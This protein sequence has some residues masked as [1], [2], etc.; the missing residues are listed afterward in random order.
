MS[1][2]DYIYL[3][4]AATTPTDPDIAQEMVGVMV[5]N[6]GNPSS[7]HALGKAAGGLVEA[8]RNSV[9]ELFHANPQQVIFTS[10]ATESNNLALKGMAGSMGDAAFIT[11]CVEHKAVLEPL[12]QLKSAGHRVEV[13]GVNRDGLIDLKNLKKSI[14]ECQR[15]HSNVVVSIIG[16][17]NELGSINPVEDIGDLC[18]RMGAIFHCDAT[19]M[20]GKVPFDPS[21]ADLISFSA[22]KIYGPKGVGV[23]IDRH[24]CLECQI[25]GGSQEEGR[26]AGTCNTPGIL[27]GAMACE[28]ASEKMAD[29][30]ELA[31]LNCQVFLEEL[32]KFFPHVLVHGGQAR[33]S[34]ILNFALPGVDV[35]SL[36]TKTPQLCVSRSSACS[37]T[38]EPSHVLRAICAPCIA[39]CSIRVS[40]GRSTTP[41]QM[42]EAA[43]LLGNTYKSSI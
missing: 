12:N 36:L 9:A 15:D 29:D 22:H 20:V 25:A 28:L 37:K 19:Q 43:L 33:S 21:C 18:N 2:S 17:N 31:Q 1:P 23:L 14:E 34:H 38:N 40:P 42:A 39:E 16:V 35:V 11:S 24:V 32:R 7:K 41:D 10:G 5:E 6:F 4:H 8:A 26:R 3:D 27:G 30:S 13:L